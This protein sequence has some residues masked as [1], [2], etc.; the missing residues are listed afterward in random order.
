MLCENCQKKPAQVFIKAIQGEEAE[1]FKL[2]Y[3]CAKEVGLL[4]DPSSKDFP[5]A[6][7]LVVGLI[8]PLPEITPKI[9][10]EVLLKRCPNCGLSFTTFMETNKFGCGECYTIFDPYLDELFMKFHGATRHI[11]GDPQALKMEDSR[12]LS[13]LANLHEKLNEAVKGENYEEAARLRD[14]ILSLKN[15]DKL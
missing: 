12:L 1:E 11:E 9:H 2:C 7:L 14:K 3:K 8:T 5:S 6:I 15:T 4:G 13:Q 10:E